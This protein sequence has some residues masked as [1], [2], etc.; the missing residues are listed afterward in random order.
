MDE[1]NSNQWVKVN[2]DWVFVP[3]GGE[4]P[5][6]KKVEDF[7]LPEL[8]FAEQPAESGGS[9]FARKPD[10]EPTQYIDI[11][12]NSQPEGEAYT[13]Y[14]DD[15]DG[16]EEDEEFYDEE[17]YY[18]EE[19]E[20]DGNK[21]MMIALIILLIALLAMVGLFIASYFS[22][23]N[24]SVAEGLQNILNVDV[25]ETEQ[26]TLGNEQQTVVTDANGAVVTESATS[27]TAVTSAGTTYAEDPE[28]ASVPEEHS[29]SQTTKD[30]E[31]EPSGVS[32]EGVDSED[33]AA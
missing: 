14:N 13:N 30:T 20:N 1:K 8:K 32:E 4:I 24:G 16:Y 29:S 6:P 18:E 3:E 9:Y 21:K 17:D 19:E 23:A 26:Y 33:P 15:I 22:S 7:D 31:A 5:K 27:A 11:S 10:D 12:S 28:T 2:G 25:E